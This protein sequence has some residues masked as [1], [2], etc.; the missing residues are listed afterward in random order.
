MGNEIANVNEQL[1]AKRQE[2]SERSSELSTGANFAGRI[3]VNNKSFILPDDYDTTFQK[4][5]D[6]VVLDYAHFNAYYKGQY[7]P[8][9]VSF[10]DCFAVGA[11]A[12]G[13]IPSQFAPEPQHEACVGCPHNEFGTRGKGKACQNRLTVAVL[14]VEDS[15]YETDEDKADPGEMFI[16]SVSPTGIKHFSKYMSSLTERNLAPFDVYTRVF[17]DPKSTY[18]QL[19]FKPIKAPNSPKGYNPYVKEHAAWLAKANDAVLSEP[20]PPEDGDE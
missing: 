20:R 4:T 6:V 9:E 8:G 11:R 12:R 16:L 18:D 7:V 5:L 3:R 2:L 13:M 14:L 17:F 10:P 15:L 1:A 19:Q